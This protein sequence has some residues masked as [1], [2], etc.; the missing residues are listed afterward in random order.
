[1]RYAWVPA[2]STDPTNRVFRRRV[3][4]AAA[5]LAGGLA[6]AGLPAPAWAKVYHA[7]DEAVGLALPG[8]DR[9]EVRDFLLTREQHERIEKLA[10]QP[11]PTDLVT[12][13]VG[14]KG[15][16]PFA[17][18]VFDTHNVRTQDETIVVALSTDGKVSGVHILSFHEPEEYLPEPRW[19]GLL[20]GRGLDS[21]LEV[22]RGVV[23]ITGSTLSTNAVV[24][25]VRRALATW[26]VVIGEK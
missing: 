5:L 25:G 19:L 6:C 14:W 22:G 15:D 23:A 1:M 13:Y 7:R 18:A 17:Y 8:A 9:V 16:A 12:V 4:A 24:G 20:A 11:L 26:Q 21:D 2:S 10:A 3:F